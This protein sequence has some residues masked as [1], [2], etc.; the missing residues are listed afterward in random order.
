MQF[1]DSVEGGNQNKYGERGLLPQVQAL[2]PPDTPQTAECTEEGLEPAY[3]TSHSKRSCV[4]TVKPSPLFWVTRPLAVTRTRFPH[5]KERSVATGVT[6]IINNTNINELAMCGQQQFEDEYSIRD[7]CRG[8][9]GS[10]IAISV[11]IAR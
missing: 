3:P 7:S 11:G 10:I 2:K 4:F 8:F 5:T 1:V 6:R 9:V